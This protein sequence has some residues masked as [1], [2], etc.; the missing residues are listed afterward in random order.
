MSKSKFIV[1]IIITLT[2]TIT[3]A[4]SVLNNLW[5]YVDAPSFIL[6]P[7]LPYI[8]VSLIH[9][10]KEQSI[11]LKELFKP[12]TD[13]DKLV[14]EKCLSYLE[15]FRRLVIVFAFVAAFIGFIG[16]LANLEDVTSVGR[17]TGVVCI[18]IFYCFMF[19]AIVIEPL[20]GSVKKKLLQ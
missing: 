19:L 6:V 4:V 18:S 13:G 12:G 11:Y 2:L 7:I 15:T 3:G 17:N 5:L 14:L 1:S 16:M 10:P 8:I 20:R 9:S